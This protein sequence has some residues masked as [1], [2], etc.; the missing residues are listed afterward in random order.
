MTTSYTHVFDSIDVKY[1]HA[2]DFW[3]TYTFICNIIINLV[4]LKWTILLFVFYL[5]HL[6]L[7]HLSFFPPS[8]RLK[9]CYHCYSH[10]YWIIVKAAQG[11]QFLTGSCFT[12]QGQLA[13]SRDLLFQLRGKGVTGISW[14]EVRDVAKHHMMH[15]T[16]PTKKDLS[17]PKLTVPRLA[18]LKFI[19]IFLQMAS[20][21]L[22][23][24]H[25]ILLSHTSSYDTELNH[26][27]RL[28]FLHKDTG[29]N[30]L[31][32]IL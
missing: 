26:L 7:V 6:F 4:R 1:F 28:N 32:D 25:S 18:H 29:N 23:D 12:L 9:M 15:K 2:A 24:S 20:V 19:T 31:I 5:S 22:R 13:K 17:N 21:H 11:Q 16:A 27:C 10:H 30:Y 3:F 8:M 14:V